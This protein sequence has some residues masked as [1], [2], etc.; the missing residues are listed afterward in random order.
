MNIIDDKNGYVIIEK[1]VGIIKLTLLKHLFLKHL[2]Y[3]KDNDNQIFVI[4]AF[5]NT[6]IELHLREI[7]I[8]RANL[9]PT[10]SSLKEDGFIF[11]SDTVGF[12]ISEK[13]I[14]M[15]DN[16]KYRDNQ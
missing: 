7:N 5:D 11:Y 3:N 15:I 13:G 14:S 16:I 6:I 1:I 8:T 10:L 2:S 4:P 9:I 12:H